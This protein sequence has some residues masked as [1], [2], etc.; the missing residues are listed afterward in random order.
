MIFN[1]DLT[2]IMEG[3]VKCYNQAGNMKIHIYG[4]DLMYYRYQ[5]A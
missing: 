3:E 4:K 5:G 1:G 2:T